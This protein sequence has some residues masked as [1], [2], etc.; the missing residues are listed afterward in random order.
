MG[1]SNAYF[2]EYRRKHK[3]QTAEANKRWQSKNKKHI[4]KYYAEWYKKNGRIITEDARR[5]VAEWR[6][7]HPQAV[8]AHNEL[9]KAIDKK[10]VIRPERCSNC[11][12]KK[13][14]EGHHEDYA[15]PLQV[16]WLCSSCHKLR[17]LSN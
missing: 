4:R 7:N 12:K 16:V 17:H 10:I 8:F 9:R 13:R 14:I 15:Y 6:E 5:I 2:R 1:A 3:K 11:H